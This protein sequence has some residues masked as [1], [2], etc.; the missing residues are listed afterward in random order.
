MVH[1]GKV[2]RRPVLHVAGSDTRTRAQQP[3][4]RGQLAIRGGVHERRVAVLVGC[5]EVGVCAD[6]R[7]DPVHLPRA[8]GEHQRCD[9]LPIRRVGLRAPLQQQR[10]R[11][12]RA[13]LGRPIERPAS[14]FVRGGNERR[15]REARQRDHV[16]ARRRQPER[17]ALDRRIVELRGR[18]GLEGRPAAT[19]GGGACVLGVANPSSWARFSQRCAPAGRADRLGATTDKGGARV[20][21]TGCLFKPKARA[22]C[23]SRG[24]LTPFR[25]NTPKRYCASTLPPAASCC[26][27]VAAALKFFRRIA[28]L[29]GS[30]GS[31]VLTAASAAPLAHSASAA[32]QL[33]LSNAILGF[34]TDA[35]AAQ[36][37]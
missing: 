29:T 2:Q 14:E 4:E 11:G 15:I 22:A 5:T 30:S 9:S 26:N 23:G 35:D 20:P 1:F 8:R 17:L 36:K 7:I 32:H 21:P 31:T 3:L 34:D 10:D 24:P 27:A 6:Q 12:G 19:P 16:P 13:G 28:V 33:T 18:H 37:V 25:Q